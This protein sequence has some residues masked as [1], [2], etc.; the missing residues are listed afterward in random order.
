EPSELAQHWPILAVAFSVSLVTSGLR[1]TAGPFLGP[2]AADFGFTHSQL[3]AIVAASA[4]LFGLALPLAGRLADQWGSRAVVAA[5]PVVLAASLVLVAG[6]RSPAV[7][8]LGYAG[9]ASLGFA[10]T[11]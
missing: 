6:T 7:F 1:F 3:S 4:L 10:A 9:L 2:L 5:G 8:A 11:S